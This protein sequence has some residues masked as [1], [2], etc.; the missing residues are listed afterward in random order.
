MRCGI[1]DRGKILRAT[2]LI[3]AILIAR[4]LRAAII[5]AAIIVA[6]TLFAAAVF[7][8]KVVAGIGA[9]ITAGQI[10][11]RQIVSRRIGGWG[12]L[13]RK[14][15][16]AWLRGGNLAGLARG[17]AEIRENLLGLNLTL[18]QGGE[19]IGNRFFF[20]EADLAGVGAYETLIEDAA[21]KLLEVLIL[22]GAQHAGADFGGLGHGIERDAPLLA[23]LA[24]FF[25]ERSHVP[26]PAGAVKFPPASRWQ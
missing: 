1:C 2:I 4:I 14:I 15:A 10:V 16:R 21:G 9:A 3:A 20:V 22:E 18:A 24:K 11:S 6:A 13:V 7:S 17:G 23:L 19:I 5:I 12:N 8:V 25:P 26:A